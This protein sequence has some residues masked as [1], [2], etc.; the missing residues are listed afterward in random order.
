M[1]AFNQCKTFQDYKNYINVFPNG[2]HILEAQAAIDVLREQAHQAIA[3]CNQMDESLAD[4]KKTCLE[5]GLLYELD[6][7]CFSLCETIADY[8]E[9]CHLFGD[10]AKHKEEVD[11][12]L[13][14]WDAFHNCNTFK[15][16]QNYV[17]D[18]PE[19]RFI[20]KAQTVIEDMV[21][22]T[23]DAIANYNQLDDSIVLLKENC[24]EKG[25][26]EEFDDKC[27]SLCSLI[28]DF[29]TYYRV[30][31][32]KA[33]HKKEVEMK[34]E[35][36]NFYQECKTCQD[37]M[38]YIERF[39]EGICINRARAVVEQV[40]SRNRNDIAQCNKIDEALATLKKSSE[41]VG[42]LEEFDDKCF[43]LCV[44]KKDFRTYLKLFG[45]NAKHKD[46]AGKHLRF[47]MWFGRIWC[48]S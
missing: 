5:L 19:G 24:Q 13:K 47:E 6:E 9:Y 14:D 48:K 31:G 17:N 18:Y 36:W 42:L 37:F 28:S 20:K 40:V 39:P 32:G 33:K 38:R 23:K 1:E 30:F 7:K 10:Q 16:Y 2:N 25:L 3:Q 43:S 21:R 29:A 35:D 27:F 12:K 11:K 15:D 41:D 34:L 46:E 44:T 45:D 22:Q 26:L 8:R 4:L